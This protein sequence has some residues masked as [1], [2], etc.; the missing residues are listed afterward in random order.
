MFGAIRKK[1]PTERLQS[2]EIQEFVCRGSGTV[3]IPLK[4]VKTGIPVPTYGTK[5]IECKG[6]GT[7]S[8]PAIIEPSENLPDGF[9]LEESNLFILVQNCYLGKIVFYLCHNIRIE[10][11]NVWSIVPQHCSSIFVDKSTIRRTLTLWESNN[12]KFEDCNINR[13]KFIRSNSNIIR[14]CTIKKIKYVEVIQW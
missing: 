4:V 3:K 5:E 10:N 8:D 7:E 9:I 2:R 1:E 11:C 12:V 14:N 6:S 13:V